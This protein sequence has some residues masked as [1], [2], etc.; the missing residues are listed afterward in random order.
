V[1]LPADADAGQ[2]PT[3][4]AQPPAA[5]GE[6]RPLGTLAQECKRVVNA[7]HP[8]G[9]K[10]VGVARLSRTI[11]V[12]LSGPYDRAD[13]LVTFL[14][15]LGLRVM[16]L[17]N[18]DS[19][20]GNAA[21]EL[22]RDQVFEHLLRLATRG[23][24]LGIF[25]APPCST[26]SIARF[27]PHVEGRDGGPPPIRTRQ[28]IRGIPNCPT[29]YRKSLREANVLVDRTCSILKA[30]T[31]AGSE[32]ALKN[33]CDRGVPVAHGGRRD[34]YSDPRHGSIW[35]MPEVIELAQHASCHTA[36]FPMCHF[37]ADW[38]KFTMG[39]N[40]SI[41]PL[42]TRPQSTR[43]TIQKIINVRATSTASTTS[44]RSWWNRVESSFPLCVRTK[45]W[46]TSSQS[47][48]ALRA[49]SPFETRS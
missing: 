47:R 13:G 33:P 26:F 25:A 34:L 43:A 8:L 10:H 37:G 49:S 27:A 31:E 9:R 29:Q 46:P 35:Q 36:T 42:T 38:Q 16:A 19:N 24:F 28:H 14:R 2:P 39:P 12:L 48:C 17:D 1:P 21:H 4:S 11:L 20:G 45:T 41:Y 6:T 18:D 15:R 5:E 30:A 22:L 44:S 23:E 3:L 40:Q 32:W 7:N